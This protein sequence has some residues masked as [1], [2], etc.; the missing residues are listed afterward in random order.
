MNIP[1]TA[2]PF[3]SA[4]PASSAEEKPITLK[5]SILSKASDPEM[6]FAP[7]VLYRLHRDQHNPTVYR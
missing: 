1:Q 2:A 7:L 5:I 3:S 6:M 4:D